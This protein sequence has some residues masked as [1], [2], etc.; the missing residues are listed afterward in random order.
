MTGPYEEILEGETCLRPPPGLRHEEISRRLHTRVAESLTNVAR[1]LPPRTR[2]QLARD[3]WVCPDLALVTAVND[4]LVLAVE[5]I[6]PEDHRWDTVTKKSIYEQLRVP[7]LWMVDPRYNNVEVYHATQYVLM[8]KE[9][10]A[11]REVLRDPLLPN[12]CFDMEELFKL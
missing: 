6:S 10:L 4:K 5:V 1:L 7:R 11:V 9:I 8:L 12:F 2:V 3:T